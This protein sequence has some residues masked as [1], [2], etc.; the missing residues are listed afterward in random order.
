MQNRREVLTRLNR[1]R[2]ANVPVANYGLVIAFSLGV[3]S[4]M[5]SPFPRLQEMLACRTPKT[6]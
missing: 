5:L 1:C 6:P 4:R 3:F 2:Q